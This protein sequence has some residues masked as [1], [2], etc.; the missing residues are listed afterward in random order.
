MK[1]INDYST[2][3]TLEK[4]TTDIRATAGISCRI[5]FHFR[6]ITYRKVSS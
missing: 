4:A 3:Y 1:Y 2:D 6:K 5:D